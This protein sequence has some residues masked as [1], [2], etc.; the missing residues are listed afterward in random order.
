MVAAKLIISRMSTND[1]QREKKTF[2]EQGATANPY[3]YAVVM[4]G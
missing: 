3:F 1:L 4:G 2:T